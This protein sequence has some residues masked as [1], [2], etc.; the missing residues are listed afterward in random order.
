MRAGRCNWIWC[1]SH[2]TPQEFISFS[3][4]LLIHQNHHL[5]TYSYT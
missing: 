5:S 4:F 2:D 3:V 1:S